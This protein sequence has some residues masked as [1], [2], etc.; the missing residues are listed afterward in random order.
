MSW[1][2]AGNACSPRSGGNASITPRSFRIS[3]SVQSR[4]LSPTNARYCSSPTGLSTFRRAARSNGLSRL[5][6]SSRRVIRAWLSL[7]ERNWMK[8]FFPRAISGDFA[9]ATDAKNKAKINRTGRSGLFGRAGKALHVLDR[10]IR[11]GIHHLDLLIGE[12][13]DDL[14]LAGLV[15]KAGHDLDAQIGKA[16]HRLHLVIAEARHELDLPV[17]P[18]D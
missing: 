9:S 18:G 4:T 16:G 3:S 15:R 1:I 2:V 5:T 10:E 6:K 11:K 8:L 13:F 17:D 14:P 7:A 12:R